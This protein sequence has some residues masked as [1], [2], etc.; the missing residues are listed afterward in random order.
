MPKS[1]ILP[2]IRALLIESFT[3]EELR[4]FCY[5]I[6]DF[7]PVY[8]KLAENTDKAEIVDTLLE[9]A[10]QKLLH[11]LLLAWAKEANPS[12]YN[13]YYPYIFPSS[14]LPLATPIPPG[15]IIG[16]LIGASPG[17]ILGQDYALTLLSSYT[18]SPVLT[19]ALAAIPFTTLNFVYIRH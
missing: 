10:D 16:G 8:D 18:P 11:E 9:Q 7:R 3:A 12:Q 1:Y 2:N 17:I 5:E 13:K 14:P 15:A 19:K 6:T 4:R